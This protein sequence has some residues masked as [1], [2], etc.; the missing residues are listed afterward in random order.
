MCPTP[1]SDLATDGLTTQYDPETQLFLVGYAEELTPEVTV[2][3]YDWFDALVEEVGCDAIRGA[4]FDFRNVKEIHQMNTRT[5][6]SESKKIHQKVDLSRLP[7]ALWVETFFQEQMLRVSMRL[8]EKS[9]RIEI[10]KSHQEALQFI[11]N[12]HQRKPADV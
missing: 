11:E 5:A 2:K 8:T 7:V 4:I 1:Y 9:E 10:V 6:R 12:W 3:M